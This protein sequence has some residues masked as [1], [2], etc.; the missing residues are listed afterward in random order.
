MLEAARGAGR[1]VHVVVEDREAD[2]AETAG[3]PVGVVGGS[4]IGTGAHIELG[5][6]GG[7]DYCRSADTRV[8]GARPCGLW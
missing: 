2:A 7:Q 4:L 1:V 6:H 3:T 5:E 8:V